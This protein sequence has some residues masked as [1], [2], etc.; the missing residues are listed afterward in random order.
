MIKIE[1]S[2]GRYGDK[3]TYFLKCNKCEKIFTIPTKRF[4]QG[5]GKYCSQKCQ[6]D[7]V[8]GEKNPNYKNG[9]KNGFAEWRRIREKLILERTLRCE[10][11][12][13]DKF[14]QIVEA[15]HKKPRSI[16]GSNKPE[17]GILVCPNC[18]KLIHRGII[19]VDGKVLPKGKKTGIHNF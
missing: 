18:H 12:G 6:R 15:H 13:Y 1:I 3:K 17:N 19:N 7:D 14:P 9:K 16:G 10:L 8:Y 5:V 2:E 4:N 11:C